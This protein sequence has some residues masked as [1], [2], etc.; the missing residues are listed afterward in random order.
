MH[1]CLNILQVIDVKRITGNITFRV[2][3]RTVKYW[4]YMSCTVTNL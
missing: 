3:D 4:V 2:G 1:N